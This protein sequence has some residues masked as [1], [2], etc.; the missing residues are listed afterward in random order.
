M[1]SEVLIKVP[2][3]PGSEVSTGTETKLGL[4]LRILPADHRTGLHSAK[5]PVVVAVSDKCLAALSVMG[6]TYTPMYPQAV[7][8]SP[9]RSAAFSV[10]KTS[11]A[12]PVD[13]AAST[14][15][16]PSIRNCFAFFRLAARCSLAALTMRG[17]R[18]VKAESKSKFMA[19]TLPTSCLAPDSD[20]AA[21]A[22][23][24]I[25]LPVWQQDHNVECYLA[26]GTPRASLS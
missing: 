1:A 25:L 12:A 22:K 23:Q 10:T 26:S 6:C 2:A 17:V 14:A 3:L 13:T 20:P 4:P 11:T 8:M 24:K 7:I 21:Y 15:F 19:P 9:K 18:S 16:S 5:S